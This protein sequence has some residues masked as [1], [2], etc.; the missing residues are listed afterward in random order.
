MLDITKYKKLFKKY[1]KSPSSELKTELVS[2]I[3]QSEM[4][5]IRHRKI[6]KPTNTDKFQPYREFMKE[7]RDEL[8]LLIKNY[9]QYPPDDLDVSK[10]SG[11]SNEEDTQDSQDLIAGK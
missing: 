11:V 2:F 7:I 9:D 6:E 1:K 4:E 5:I 10:F 8:N 3:C